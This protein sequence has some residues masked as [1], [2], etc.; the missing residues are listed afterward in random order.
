MSPTGQESPGRL[1]IPSR[2]PGSC[3]VDI[4]L[5]RLFRRLD[6]GRYK[7]EKM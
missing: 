7:K 5:V 2:M 3:S 4:E 6:G 1:F